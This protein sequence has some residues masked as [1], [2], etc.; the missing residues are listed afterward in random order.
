MQRTICLSVSIHCD[1][2]YAVFYEYYEKSKDDRALK[3]AKYIKYG[4]INENEIW[5]L[6]YGFDFEDIEWL[7]PCIQSI[8]KTEIVFND[9]V[10]SLTD[11]QLLR[12]DRYRS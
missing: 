10:D 5:L 11:E 9:N 1:I 7:R 3:L 4:T 8:D 2:F 6:R 12:I